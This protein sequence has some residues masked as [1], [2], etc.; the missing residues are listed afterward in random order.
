[1]LTMKPR[2]VDSMIEGRASLDAGP[3]PISSVS[4]NGPPETVTV[5]HSHPTWL[6]RTQTWM[7]NQVKYLPQNIRSHVVCEKLENPEEFG[8]PNIHCLTERPWWSRRLDVRLR[9]MNFRRHLSFVRAVTEQ[10]RPNIFHSHFGTVAWKNLH[11]VTGTGVKHV[12]TFY[13]FDVTY[14]AGHDSMRSRYQ[15]LFSQVAAV[16]CEGS[17]MAQRLVELGCREDRVIVHHLGV[18]LER[19]PYEPRS[20]RPATP[21]RILISGRF[22]EKKGIPFAIRAL[23]EIRDQVDLRITIIGDALN[24]S[25]DRRE[26][27][28]ILTMLDRCGLTGSTKMMGF[29]P[30]S[31]LLSEARK[32]H[33]FLSPSV[34]TN[35]GDTEGGAPV[36]IIEMAASGMPIV[37]SLHCDIPEVILNG[38]TG[39]LAPER[40][41]WRL[42]QHLQWLIE[43]P[44]DWRP[45]L[46]ASRMRI[47]KEYNCEIQGRRLAK[48][49]EAIAGAT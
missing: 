24:T 44:G 32:H 9:K 45:F 15:E 34:K 30:Y 1:M 12:V 33:V 6:P 19:I 14:W 39:W 10:L 36:S 48:R 11:A 27:A 13:G 37:S 26:K 28:K 46:D 29:Q 47:E 4:L 20:W 5:L 31:V 18:P 7:F 22:R 8:V 49:Y 40:D 38:E 35:D 21:F 2:S 43:H 3:R 42:A 23:A 16:F 41:W 17:A 25:G